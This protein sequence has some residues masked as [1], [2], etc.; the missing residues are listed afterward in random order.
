M[1]QKYNMAERIKAP[2]S[3]MPKKYRKLIEQRFK[4]QGGDIH[5]IE[6]YMLEVDIYI[7]IDLANFW[8]KECD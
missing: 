4:A 7:D 5:N 3:S 6:K 1:A 8:P 2:L